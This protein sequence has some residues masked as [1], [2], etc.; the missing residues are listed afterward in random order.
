MRFFLFP[1]QKSCAW[2]R[3]KDLFNNSIINWWEEGDDDCGEN[4]GEIRLPLIVHQHHHQHHDYHVWNDIK[5]E[6]NDQKW[7]MLFTLYK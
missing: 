6:D 4:F 7:L 3:V 1:A 2:W 5:M